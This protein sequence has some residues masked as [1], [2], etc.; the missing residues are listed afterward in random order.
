MARGS[1][2]RLLACGTILS[3]LWVSPF[4][5]LRQV[6]EMLELTVGYLGLGFG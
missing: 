6:V 2:L 4:A 1:V 5:F 3:L